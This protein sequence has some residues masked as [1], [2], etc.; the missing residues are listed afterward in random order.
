MHWFSSEKK[1]SWR[2]AVSGLNPRI[3]TF[4]GGR[5]KYVY[6]KKLRL[7]FWRQYN[8]VYY[9]SSITREMTILCIYIIH[10][11]YTIRN[12]TRTAHKI[13][14][15]VYGVIFSP[16]LSF[17]QPYL[18]ESSYGKNEKHDLPKWRLKIDRPI[19]TGISMRIY[20]IIKCV[21]TRKDSCKNRKSLVRLR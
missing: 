11:I 10:N 13:I 16:F 20:S 17:M 14:I 4:N 18:F 3:R 7:R 6:S 19:L 5:T 1:L 9:T 2:P 15:T 21:K 12:V 8:W